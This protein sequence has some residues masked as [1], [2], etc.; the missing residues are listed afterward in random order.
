MTQL[1]REAADGR[2]GAL[3]E[4][5]PLVYDELRRL[6]AAVRQQGTGATLDTS[7][8]VHEA[9][10]RL[11][12]TDGAVPW[13]GRQHFLRVAARAMRQVLVRNAEHRGAAKRGGGVAD[14]TLA[15]DLHGRPPTDDEV[16]DLDQAL[17]RLDAINTRQAAVVE[18]RFF[19]G[20]TVEE[21]ADVLG[22]SAPTVAR[23]WR[24][25]R[26]WLARELAP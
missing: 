3:D 23:D 26:V 8:L 9:Y 7:A 6:A 5:L 4:A 1:L 25:A 19:A 17:Q 14:V 11:A 22:V 12:Q 2:A 13:A 21:T 16:L 20:L 18:V 15:D 10:L 24:L